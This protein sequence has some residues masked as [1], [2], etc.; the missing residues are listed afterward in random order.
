MCGHAHVDAR[1]VRISR[2]DR[3]VDGNAYDWRQPVE[4]QVELECDRV[5][6]WSD[7]LSIR[8]VERF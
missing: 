6:Y 3:G 8:R 1:D 7:M 2:T 4:R 5:R